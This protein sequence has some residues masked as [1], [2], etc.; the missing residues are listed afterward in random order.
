MEDMLLCLVKYTVHRFFSFCYSAFLFIKPMAQSFSS[1]LMI[2]RLLNFSPSLF[3]LPVPLLLQLPSIIVT[4]L[5]KNYGLCSLSWDFRITLCKQSALQNTYTL[6]YPYWAFSKKDGT[7]DLRHKNNSTCW[8]NCFLYIDNFLVISSRPYQIIRLVETLR[9]QGAYITPCQEESQKIDALTKQ[10]NAF[11]TNSSLRDIVDFYSD[12][13]TRFEALCADLF[14][15]MGYSAQVTPPTNDGGY[16]IVLTKDS[17]K[18]IVECK[19]YSVGHHIGRPTIQKLVGA[20]SIAHAD[21]MLFVTTSNYSSGAIEYA[22]SSGVSL[23]N[24]S[25]LLKLLSTYGFL[26]KN[27]VTIAPSEWQLTVSDLKP[28]V[29]TDIYSR[30]FL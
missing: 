26:H 11:S 25:E 15:K 21:H 14:Q 23:I 22:A 20:N 30:F 24:G 7:A 28:Y 19:C 2:Y 9:N 13:P 6:D 29:P 4:Y 8:K 16:D 10:Y 17:S 1:I 12:N 18:T 27:D 5:K 3:L